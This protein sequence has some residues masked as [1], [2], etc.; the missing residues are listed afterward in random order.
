MKILRLS[1]WALIAASTVAFAAAAP[2]PPTPAPAWKLKDVSGNLVSSEQLK[3]K[4]VVVDFWATWCEPCRREIPGYVDL[5]KKYAQDGLVVVG[6]SLDDKGPA[7]VKQFVEKY[8]VSYLVVMGNEEITKAFGGMDGIPTTFIIDRSGQIRE[9]KLGVVPRA[10]FEQSV[11][12]Y[13]QPASS[14][15]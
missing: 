2:V 14:A 7:V 15:L 5:Q 13:L 11:L 9:R 3:G 4:V 6:I 12:K 8:Q 10:V 1:S